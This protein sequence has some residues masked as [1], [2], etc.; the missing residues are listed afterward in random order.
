MCP[1]CLFSFKGLKEGDAYFKVTGTIHIKFQI[2]DFFFPNNKKQLPLR[3]IIFSIQELLGSYFHFFIACV[4]ILFYFNLVIN[5]QIS[6]K[7]CILR[8]SAY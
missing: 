7:H 3:Y 2:C 1:R 6:N 8:C 5:G 4:L